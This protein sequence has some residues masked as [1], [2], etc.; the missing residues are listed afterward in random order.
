MNSY[1]TG[2]ILLSDMIAAR[3][4]IRFLVGRVNTNQFEL[5]DN[6]PSRASCF[7]VIVLFKIIPPWSWVAVANV[8]RCLRTSAWASFLLIIHPKLLLDCCIETRRR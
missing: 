4:G 1:G 7:Q 2:F 5:N 3:I 8:S 6:L